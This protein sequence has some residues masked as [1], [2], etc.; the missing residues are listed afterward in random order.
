VVPFEN[1][2]LALIASGVTSSIAALQMQATYFCGH[3][4]VPRFSTRDSVAKKCI[5]DMKES[6]S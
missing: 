3:G 6:H 1:A 5:E 2:Q 4:F